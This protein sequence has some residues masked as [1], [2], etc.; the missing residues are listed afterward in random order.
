MSSLAFPDPYQRITDK[1]DVSAALGNTKP[2]DL[3]PPRPEDKAC[4]ELGK[5]FSEYLIRKLQSGQYDPI[6]AYIVHVPKSRLTTRPAALLSLPDRVVYE[7][8]VST[9]R[10]RIERFLLGKSI[11]FWPRGDSAVTK[12]WMC[13]ERSVIRP[14][15]RYVVRSDVVGFYE[16]VD[17]ELLVDTIVRVTGHRDIAEALTH[18]LGR[19]MGSKRGLPQGLLPSDTLATVYLGELDNTMVRHGFL[20]ARHGD[21]IRVATKNYDDACFAVRSLEHG[22][23]KLGLLLNID[24]T[25]VFRRETYTSAM[26]SFVRTG[27][28][29]HEEAKSIKLQNLR[30]DQEQ[31][32][33]AI[34]ETDMEQ[35]GWDVFYHGT[36]DLDQALELI[37]PHITPDKVAVAE[38][39]FQNAIERRPGMDNALPK[40]AFHQQLVKSLVDLSAGRSK[41]G[42]CHTRDLMRL[43]PDK[44]QML[45]S[46]LGALASEAKVA[47]DIVMQVESALQRPYITEWE[48]SCMIGVLNKVPAHVS[49]LLSRKLK[50]IVTTTTEEWLATI[51][52]AKLLARRDELDRELVLALWNRCPEVFQTDLMVAVAYAATAPWTTAFLSSSGSN[53]IH[54]V[55][56][57]HEQSSSW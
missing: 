5:R 24:K 38:V 20:Y 36:I 54:E 50:N 1:I 43:F 23:R 37:R 48:K 19:V 56:V 30:H 41:V 28:E 47:D 55:V 33:E 39:Q 21:D 27:K 34:E 57:R 40:E 8:L 13:F 22:L 44:T 14:D 2:N 10:L 17:H 42:V 6:P 51:E 15:L 35:L 9:L 29:A 52:I 18:F 16:S 45:C 7:A 12:R 26:E 31:L 49:K 53:P 32:A 11:V 4:G 25:R 3:L 46:Y